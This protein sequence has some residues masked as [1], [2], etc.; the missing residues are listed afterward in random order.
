MA[1][2]IK[3]TTSIG[4]VHGYWTVVGE[5]RKHG[6]TYKCLCKCKC[7]TVRPVSVLHLREGSSK[8]CGCFSPGH[9][10]YH[11]P[12]NQVWRDMKDRC[13][14]KNSQK[15]KY[16]GGRGISVCDDWRDNFLSFYNWA[17]PHWRDGLSLDRINNNGNYTPENCRFVSQLVQTY[18]RR[19]RKDNTSGVPGVRWNKARKKWCAGAN[20]KGKEYYLGGFERVEDAAAARA[21]WESEVLLPSIAKELR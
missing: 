9:G 3:H 4:N 7:G 12:L 15:F 11:H 1:R 10:L 13:N 14:N 5:M 16:Y 19:P 8:S 20:H 6:K 21:K 2:K 18:N 17:L